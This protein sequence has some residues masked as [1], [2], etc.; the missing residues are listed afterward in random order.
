MFGSWV[1]CLI[2]RVEFSLDRLNQRYVQLDAGEV[3][4]KGLAMEARM[5]LHLQ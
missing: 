2:C 1:F 5:G 3:V 4:D